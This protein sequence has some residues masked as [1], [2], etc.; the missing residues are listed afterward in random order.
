VLATDNRG[1]FPLAAVRS[2][3]TGEKVMAA[4]GSRE[5]SIWGPILHQIEADLDR[6]EVRVENLLKYLESIQT[7]DGSR[8]GIL[9]TGLCQTTRKDI[10]QIG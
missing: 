8:C 4:H 7:M 1:Q 5:M 10:R 3:I 9:R 6:G 2:A